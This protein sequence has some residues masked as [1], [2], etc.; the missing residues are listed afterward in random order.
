MKDCK[1][2]EEDTDMFF[3]LRMWTKRRVFG[4][5]SGFGCS[6]VVEVVVDPPKKSC[7]R[8]DSDSPQG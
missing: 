8:N 2:V 4:S 1:K 5:V 3:F 6:N 7:Q